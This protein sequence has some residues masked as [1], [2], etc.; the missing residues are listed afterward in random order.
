MLSGVKN[1]VDEDLDYVHKMMSYICRYNS[2]V[3]N[4]SEFAESRKLT[5]EYAKRF[6]EKQ[7][8]KF[9]LSKISKIWEE[10]KQAAPYVFAFY[11][12]FSQISAQAHSIDELVNILEFLAADQNRIEELLAVARHTVNILTSMA[13]R[14]VRQRDFQDVPPVMPKLEVFSAD[15]IHIISAINPENLSMKDA[16]PWR[17]KTNCAEKQD[18][19]ILWKSS[20]G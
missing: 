3:A 11:P 15:E 20:F 19:V 7:Q 18:K 8:Q 14:N 17:P 5:I 13:V 10:N 16:Q 1:A 4:H 9:G 12:V 6:V 2:H